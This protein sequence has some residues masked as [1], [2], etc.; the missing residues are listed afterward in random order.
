MCRQ[1]TDTQETPET[2]KVRRSGTLWVP[3]AGGKHTRHRKMI[4]TFVSYGAAASTAYAWA[5][6]GGGASDARIGAC[7]ASVPSSLRLS[8]NTQVIL[9]GFAR[10]KEWEENVY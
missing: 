2:A 1:Q 10:L 8:Q 4:P 5:G 7:S 3:S 9:L 6:G